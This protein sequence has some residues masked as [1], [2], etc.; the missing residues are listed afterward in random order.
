[1]ASVINSNHTLSDIARKSSIKLQCTA[2]LQNYK[3]FL[4]SEILSKNASVKTI[5]I[6]TTTKTESNSNY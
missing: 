1:M 5:K 3:L 4:N 2:N 6:V